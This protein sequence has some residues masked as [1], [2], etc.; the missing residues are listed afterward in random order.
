M[1]I[2]PIDKKTSSNYQTTINDLT[3]EHLFSCFNFLSKID[4]MQTVRVNSEWKN[5]AIL[6]AGFNEFHS[7]RSLVRFLT[8][9]L[10][11]VLSK[12]QKEILNEI[13][14]SQKTFR[15]AKNLIAVKLLLLQQ[16]EWIITNIL[17]NLNEERLNI[18]KAL[19]ESKPKSFPNF[20]EDFFELALIYKEID[21]ANVMPNDQRSNA[22]KYC[23]RRLA[24]LGYI[25]KAIEVADTIYED[26]N[27]MPLYLLPKSEA[28]GIIS[29]AAIRFG[30]FD[31]A[32]KAAKSI[33]CVVEKSYFLSYISG[34]L[35]Q[36]RIIE[37]AIEVAKAI[38]I[39]WIRLDAFENIRK[40]LIQL[41]NIDKAKEVSKINEISS[42][43]FL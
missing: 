36:R 12:K 16:K 4:M 7:V 18:L 23:S 37:K 24:E 15:D 26:A 22:L 33:P 28:F 17:K 6:T 14:N 21:Q 11:D 1:S 25:D 32:I 8:E 27:A 43:I 9:N 20:F 41:G 29:Q 5:I 31:K 35:I 42:C 10:N 13:S 39:D 30:F 2:Q 40:N 34:V 19:F 3:Q 38:P